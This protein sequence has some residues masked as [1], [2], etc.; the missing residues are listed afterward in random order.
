MTKILLEAPVFTV[1]AAILAAS[2][3]IDRIE[4]CSNFGDG[5]ET[6]SAGAIKFLKQSIS[7]PIFAM[8]RPRGGDFVYSK[9][10]VFV[11]QEDIRVLGSLGAD[12]FVFGAL[13]PEGKLDLE[14]NKALVECASGLPCTL[15]RAFDSTV[16]I[17]DSLE[18]AISCGFQRI[19]TSGGE[20][21]VSEGLGNL[22]SLLRSAGDRIIII[23]GGG[24]KP[25]HIIDLH[26]SGYLREVHASC[27]GWRPTLSK[28]RKPGLELTMQD[29]IL[30]ID[31]E[32][33]EAFRK[34][35]EKLP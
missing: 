8:I 18:S 2:Y 15:H 10:E 28:F 23:P 24:L 31:R 32:V 11:M 5:G 14:T 13:T 6:P 12:G 26:P 34:N 17:F 35:F 21:T 27:K 25:E 29:N 19:L 33:S 7:I 9:E 4:L 3:G 20:N 22:L 30:T 16:D 1:E